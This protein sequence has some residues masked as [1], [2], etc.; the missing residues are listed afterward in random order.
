MFINI[1]KRKELIDR[2]IELY[3]K[4]QFLLVDKAIEEYRL[5]SQA[6]I[7]R[8]DK[9]CQDMATR[10]AVE[11]GQYEH[12]FHSTKELKGI[13]IAKLEAKEEALQLVVKA[14]QE[15]ISA[16]Q[17]LLDSKNAE[18]KRLNEII[19]MLI[20]EQPIHITT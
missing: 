8:M 7:Q 18:I 17:N 3:K 14:R 6:E 10:C 4:E 12:T 9:Q 11:L 16:D 19:T 20:K 5:K 2:E 13:E 15:V 1:R